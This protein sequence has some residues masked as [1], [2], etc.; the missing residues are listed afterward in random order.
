MPANDLLNSLLASEIESDDGPRRVPRQ[1][2][3]DSRIWTTPGVEYQPARTGECIGDCAQALRC[4]K[5]RNLIVASPFGDLPKVTAELD[6]QALDRSLVS[7][8]DHL[9]ALDAMPLEGVVTF[10]CVVW[11]IHR[12][13]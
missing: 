2:D 11:G 12:A 8:C 3:C 5:H 6:V 10:R 13:S 9:S 7:G 4:R 1:R